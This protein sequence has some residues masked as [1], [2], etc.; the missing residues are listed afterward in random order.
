MD[1][2]TEDLDIYYDALVDA[3]NSGEIRGMSNADRAHNTTILRFMLD[4]ARTINMF[5][6]EM[7]VFRAKFYEHINNNSNCN[8]LGD[9]LKEKLVSSLKAFI[10][11]P[12][13]KS[14]CI[15]L[16]NYDP[17]YFTDLIDRNIFREGISSGR[18]KLMKLN[19]DAI[20]RSSLSHFTVTD[21][22]IVRMEEDKETHRGLCTVNTG[23]DLQS[24]LQNNFD[25][26]MKASDMV[27]FPY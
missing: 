2:N 7:S 10:A 3:L 18:I 22:G 17:E 23:R 5:C 4:Y 1:P 12:E 19:G 13:N 20:L 21:N 14:L 24:K 27:Q 26:M 15:I 25:T 6:G 11:S 16:E 9:T 8:T